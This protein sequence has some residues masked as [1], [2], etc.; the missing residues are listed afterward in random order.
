MA[1]ARDPIERLEDK[2]DALAASI[3]E[4]NV[5]IVRLEA[6]L[7]Q[8]RELA[9]A[10]VL[11]VDGHEKRITL[12]EGWQNRAEGAALAGKVFWGLLIAAA[13]VVEWLM[14]RK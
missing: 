8:A 3:S 2:I 7:D 6:A 12:L 11:R 13:G 9:S 10:A 14:H 5:T 1:L 4:L